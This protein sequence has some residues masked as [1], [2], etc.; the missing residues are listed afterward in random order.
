MNAAPRAADHDRWLPRAGSVKLVW[1]FNQWNN[2]PKPISIDS[3]E[4][5]AP[6][7]MNRIA[8][9]VAVTFVLLLA[10]APARSAVISRDWLTP[11]DGLLTYDDVNQREWLDLTQTQLFNFTGDTLEQRYQAVIAEVAPGGMFEGFNVAIEDDVRSLSQSA[12]INTMTLSYSVNGS[13]SSELILMLGNTLDSSNLLAN[14]SATGFVANESNGLSSVWVVSNLNARTE[15][16]AGFRDL[17]RTLEPAYGFFGPPPSLPT[18]GVW[19]YRQIPEP[20]SFRILVYSTIVAAIVVCLAR[21][22]LLF[23]S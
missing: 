22:R 2:R 6:T 13:V 20:S 14:Q 17:S 11:G 9:I 23:Q 15:S 5:V 18:S 7:T 12:G 19:L 21:R 16:H 8:A 3:P 10:I 1:V 4:L